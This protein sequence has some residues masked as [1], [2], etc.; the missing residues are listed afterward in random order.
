M[1]TLKI[2][3]IEGRALPLV[4]SAASPMP[5]AVAG[6]EYIVPF[7]AYYVSA[8][9]NGDCECAELDK[10]HPELKKARDASSKKTTKAKADSAP[11]QGEK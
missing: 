7:D 9:K 11:E 4:H 6:E 5:C 8:W 2:K 3:G 10:Q 1:N